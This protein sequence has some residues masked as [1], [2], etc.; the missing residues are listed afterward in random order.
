MSQYAR[1]AALLDSNTAY[2]TNLVRLA[3]H[4]YSR[5][6]AYEN[7][8]LEGGPRDEGITEGMGAT[9]TATALGGSMALLTIGNTGGTELTILIN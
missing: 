3:R 6:F 4:L 8:K 1:V 5:C 9:T 2:G 7:K